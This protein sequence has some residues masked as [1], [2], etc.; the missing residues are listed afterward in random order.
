MKMKPRDSVFLRVWPWALPIGL[1]I[2]TAGKLLD[3]VGALTDYWS[4]F[5]LGCGAFLAIIGAAMLIARICR[6]KKMS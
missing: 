6:H 3:A 4:G 2:M 1:V 5:F